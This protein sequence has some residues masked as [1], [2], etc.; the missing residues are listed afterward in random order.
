VLTRT[1]IDLS[2]HFTIYFSGHEYLTMM[3][4]AHDFMTFAY[5]M[6]SLYKI[7]DRQY[8]H[9]ARLTQTHSGT[10]YLYSHE[11]TIFILPTNQVYLHSEGNS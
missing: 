2:V 4:R 3:E 1:I 6:T 7:V 11:E 10:K 5:C 9:I 8:V